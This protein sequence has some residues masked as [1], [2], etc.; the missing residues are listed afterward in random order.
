MFDGLEVDRLRQ[1]LITMQRLSKESIDLLR[2][3]I[4]TLKSDAMSENNAMKSH[5]EHLIKSYDELKNET[6]NHERELIQRLT[7]DHELEMN[8]LSKKLFAKDDEISTLKS[9]NEQLEERIKACENDKL[10]LE[11]K[12]KEI[13]VRLQE[14]EHKIAMQ[15]ADKENAIRQLKEDHRNEIESLRCKFKLITSMDSSP[16]ETSLDKLDKDV[17]ELSSH[18]TIIK[19]MEENFENQLQNA[20]KEALEKERANAKL[21][22]STS[23]RWSLTPSSPSGKSPKESQEIFKRILEEKDRQLDQMREREQFL[24]KE[25]NR[26]KEIIQS[27]TDVE[28][29]ESQVSLYKEKLDLVMSE[30]HKLEKDL[31]KEKAKRAKMNNLAQGIAI[32]SCIK[33]DTVMV[34]WNS[35]YEQYTI[36][37]DS[38]VLYF[39][40]A[41]SYNDLQ[42]SPVPSNSFP[43]TCYCIGRV[44]NKEYC[45]AKKDEN[46]YKVGKGTKFY[47][48]KVRPRSPSARDMERSQSERKKIRR[49]TGNFNFKL[50]KFLFIVFS[51]RLYILVFA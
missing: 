4:V 19:Q 21:T 13:E 47:R 37:Q 28:L 26:L 45:H 14:M 22:E 27:L 3:Q 34:V 42:L 1:L 25:S 50:C 31:E 17:I 41:D 20:I 8:D 49:S 32:N 9:E 46:R 39:L 38:S 24:M 2:Q 29:N 7:V 43:R 51:F 48:V 30:K 5:L 35:M 10:Q 44:V 16:S 11:T 18:R 23:Q 15:S 33:D 36:V 12:T 6:K 40:H